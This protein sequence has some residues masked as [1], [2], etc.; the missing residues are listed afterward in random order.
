MLRVFNGVVHR[1]NR[2]CPMFSLTL[3]AIASVVADDQI[4]FRFQAR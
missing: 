1:E 4:I 2:Q 3:F